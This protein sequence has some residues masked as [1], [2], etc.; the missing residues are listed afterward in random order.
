MT[1]SSLAKRGGGGS[2][3]TSLCALS[4]VLL[5]SACVNSQ[6]GGRS[7]ATPSTEVTQAPST[8]DFQIFLRNLEAEA[9]AQGIRPQTA[10]LVNTAQHINKIIEL[11]R[12]Q[13]EFTRTLQQYLEGAVNAGRVRKGQDLMV[14]NQALLGKVSAKYGVQPQY[15]VALWGIETDFGRLTGGYP[16]VSALSTLAYDGRRSA[17]FRGELLNALRIIDA[18][19]ISASA[20][21]G[22]WAGAMGQCQFM[23]SSFLKFAQDGNGDGRLD[24]WQTRADVLASAANYLSQSGWQGNQSWGRAVRIPDSLDEASLGLEKTKTLTEWA[25]LGVVSR[26]G[27]PLPQGSLQGSI[28][29]GDKDG[30]DQTFLVYENFRV[31]MKWNRSVY[32]ALAV[33]HLADRLAVAGS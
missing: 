14:E 17:Y 25:A 7:T 13:P 30:G 22:S 15:I 12:K 11:D 4:L 29:R 21:S 3:L 2:V 10:S 19:H 20:M 8:A 23:P 1:H 16:V 18:G 31:I 6:S 33:G 24:I 32:F 5:S 28:I 9:V 27:T 26:D